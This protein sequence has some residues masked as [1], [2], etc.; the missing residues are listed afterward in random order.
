[1]NRNFPTSTSQ[2]PIKALS[3]NA[4][5]R[6]ALQKINE[7][8]CLLCVFE[9]EQTNK[10]AVL[11]DSDIRKSLLKGAQLTDKALN[12]ANHNPVTAKPEASNDELTKLAKIYRYREIPIVDQYGKLQDIFIHHDQPSDQAPGN[13]SILPNSLFILAGGSG[14]RLKSVV[15]DRP[16]PLANVGDRPILQTLILSARASGIRKFF[17]SVNYLAHQIE[18]HLKERVYS[19]L[20]ITIIREHKKLGTAGSIGLIEDNC[21]HPLLVCNADIL[22]KVEFDKLLYAHTETNADITCAVREHKVQIPF[23]VMKIKNDNITDI[24]EKPESIYHVN[25]G[26]YVLERSVTQ[27]IPLDK[28]FDMPQLIGKVIQSGGVVAPFLVHEYWKD[29]GQPEDFFSANREYSF[30]FKDLVL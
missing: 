20:D 15:Q 28:Y 18:E 4:T 19:E 7:T 11:T 26:I 14:E 5:I 1:M 8:K 23:G 9:I 25:A 10:V 3:H 27:H 21:N 6:D 12:W 17:I 30:H 16:K 22:T 24:E 13:K 29:V 2:K